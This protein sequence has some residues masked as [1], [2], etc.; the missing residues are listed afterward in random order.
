VTSRRSG[1]RLWLLAFIGFWLLHAGWAL[2]APYNGPPD[3]QQHVHRAAGLLHG[4]LIAE[5]GLKFDWQTVPESL[6]R[7]WCFPS[8][9][10]VAADCDQEPGG[11]ETPLLYPTSA[12]RFNPVYYWVTSWPL[13]VSPAW[14]GIMLS[15]LLNGAVMAALL[16][17]AVVV[18]CRW[19]RHRALLAGIVVA[20]TPMTAHLG[21][22]INPNGI[23]IAA[24]LAL[25]T[26]LIAL[27]HEQREGVDRAVVALAGVSASVLVTPRFTGVMWLALILGVLLVPSS[28][29]R[30]AE[31]ARSRTVRIWSAVVAASTVAALAWTVLARPAGQ[32]VEDRGLSWADVVRFAVL[33]SWPN[34]ANQM[35]G[36]MGWAETLMPRLVYV[37]WFMAA[38]LLLLGGLAVGRRVERWRLLALFFGTFAPLIALEVLTANQVGWFNQ[39]RYFLPGA[40]GLPLIG[41]Y[42]LARRGLSAE[43]LRA[44]T[45]LL[46]VL[47]LPIHL[48]CLAY[49]MARWNSGLRSLNPF[50]GSWQPPYGVLLPLV[51]GALA[52]VVLLLAYWWASRIPAPPSVTRP[53]EP[54][55]TAPAETVSASYV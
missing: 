19:T 35:V 21:G 15:R 43:Q 13:A 34:V 45:R 41:A 33:D 18:A 27:L 55:A 16:A 14:P 5:P 6:I 29:A 22:A 40:V 36:V 7:G 52:V 44:A 9:P 3:E 17:C 53:E 23:E 20:A 12:A 10:D 39:G 32:V 49:T 47:L 42:V 25:F 50:N 38:G 37:A 51:C 31:L 4:E 8:R 2:A 30:L 46:A 24:G 28:R 54:R 1:T 48:V 26:A 11:A